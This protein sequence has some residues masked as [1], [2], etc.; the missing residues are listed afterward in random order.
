MKRF[1]SRKNENS[2]R[3]CV[4]FFPFRYR[5]Q[6]FQIFFILTSMQTLPII[7][8]IYEGYKNIIN[9]N[10][11]LQKRWKYSLGTDLEQ[12]I[13]SCLSELIMAK[14]APQ[15]LKASYLIKASS[16]LEICMLKLRLYLE[17]QLANETKIF[18]AQSLLAEVGRML[19]GWI[20]ANQS[21]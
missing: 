6:V 3:S 13:L 19:G 12:S 4:G 18:Q 5:H 7:N 15:P 14:N 10:D 11:A 1:C 9:I 2:W 21:K 17:L 20:K 16:H 8:K